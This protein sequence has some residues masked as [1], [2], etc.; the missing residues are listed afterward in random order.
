M[1]DVSGMEVKV[2]GVIVP[3]GETVQYIDQQ[4]IRHMKFTQHTCRFIVL[5]E[6]DAEICFLELCEKHVERTLH[7]VQ[8]KNGKLLWKKKNKHMLALTSCLLTST[9]KVRV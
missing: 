2:L 4:N 3:A 1:F 6:A 5:S 8:F 9:P 7:W